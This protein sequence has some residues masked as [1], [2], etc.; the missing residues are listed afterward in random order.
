LAIPPAFSALQ[1]ALPV[2]ISPII[3]VNFGRAE[4]HDPENRFVAAK[5]ELEQSRVSHSAGGR[6][7]G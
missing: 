5:F 1:L 7:L 4:Q 6:R 2:G 3:A